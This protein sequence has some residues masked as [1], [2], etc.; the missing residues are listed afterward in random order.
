MTLTAI[1]PELVIMNILVAT[2]TIT[3]GYTCKFLHFDPVM[4]GYLMTFYA[5][6][7]GMLPP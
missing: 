2:C 3:K 1:L 6:C 5:I 7:L 4:E